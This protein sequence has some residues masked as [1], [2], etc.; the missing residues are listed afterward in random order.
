MKS[1]LILT[2][3]NNMNTGQWLEFRWGGIGGSEVGAIMGLN[4]YQSSIELFYAKI[5]QPIFRPENIAMF[6]GKETEPLLA[7]MWQYWGGTPESMIE[8][9]RSNNIVRKCHRVNAYIKNPKYPWLFCSVDRV[10]N[11][12]EGRGEGVLEVKN[13]SGYAADKWESGFPPSYVIQIQT[14]LTVL[15]LTWGESAIMK[16]GREFEVL[17]FE[18]NQSIAD[19]ILETT[20]KFWRKVEQ[21]K[22]IVTQQF[23]AQ[24]NFNHKAM[25]ELTAELQTLEPEPDGSDAFNNFLKEKYRIALPGERIGTITQLTDAQAHKEMSSRIKELTEQKQLHENKLKNAFGHESCD[26]FDF[27]ENG[28]VSWKSDS[29][30]VRRFLNKTK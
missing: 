3:T 5:G 1:S 18:F 16:D 8:N 7:Q 20:E 6:M 9:Y 23:E 14:Y 24:R 21:A 28:Y 19:G 4:P 15:E 29:N 27:G 25:D 13:I 26:R 2:P 17:P 11:K 10:I 22:I 12:Q 30:G